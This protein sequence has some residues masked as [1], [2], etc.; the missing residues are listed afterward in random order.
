MRIPPALTPRARTPVA[1][2]LLSRRNFHWRQIY[3]PGSRIWLAPPMEFHRPQTKPLVFADVPPEDQ[4]N[5][6]RLFRI[7]LPTSEQE[8]TRHEHAT[9]PWPQPIA[10]GEWIR[11][12]AKP[13]TQP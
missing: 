2:Q 7:I 11:M 5:V 4:N 9:N 12:R 6:C 13:G 10:R 8:A 1:Q 3:L